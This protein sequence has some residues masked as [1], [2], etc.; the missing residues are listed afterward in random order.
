MARKAFDLTREAVASTA[1]TYA[2]ATYAKGARFPH[3]DLSISDHD[4]ANLFRCE[5][6]DFTDRAYQAPPPPP[7]AAKQQQNPLLARK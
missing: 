1:F 5:R 6:I 7:P 4:V 2:G 3:R